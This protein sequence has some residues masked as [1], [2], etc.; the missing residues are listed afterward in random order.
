MTTGGDPDNEDIIELVRGQ[1]LVIFQRGKPARDVVCAG[2]YDKCPLKDHKSLQRDERN[3]SKPGWFRGVFTQKGRLA[4][5]W[6][7]SR[8]SASEAKLLLDARKLANRKSAAI[9]TSGTRG[10]AEK[11]LLQLGQA[12]PESEGTWDNCTD[13]PSGP[14]GGAC[15]ALGKQLLEE[16]KSAPSLNEVTEE[17]VRKQFCL[18]R[19]EANEAYDVGSWVKFTHGRIVKSA[20]VQ[21][22]YFDP[23]GNYYL[24][25]DE[26][27]REIQT[28]GRFILS[29]TKAVEPERV[30][31]RDSTTYLMA[32]LRQ[33]IQL[34]QQKEVDHRAELKKVYAAVQSIQTGAT[35]ELNK[36]PKAQAPAFW[37]AISKG[38]PGVNDTGV[39]T[40]AEARQKLA[41]V[42]DGVWRR[43]VSS[44]QEG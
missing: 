12:S 19:H 21:E 44:D 28:E 33:T 17:V 5:G 20:V 30:I 18:Q 22:V 39:F 25:K 26:D 43:R 42:T 34:M 13:H 15:I 38:G 32:T 40:F 31:E 29:V 35:D 36:P 8:M 6:L 4:G 9:A 2:K 11:P 3:R 7:D 41:G 1:C 27:G 16:A 14:P 10:S 24:L 37:Y 23:A